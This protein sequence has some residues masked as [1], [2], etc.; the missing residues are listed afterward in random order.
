MVKQERGPSKLPGLSKAKDELLMETRA[1]V[2]WP[3]IKR[4]AFLL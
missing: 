4:G 2:G 1:Q 3:D